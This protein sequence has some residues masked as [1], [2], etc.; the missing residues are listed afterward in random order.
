MNSSS[1]QISNTS[2]IL[3]AGLVLI[4]L[5]IGYREK[6]GIDRDMIIG[7]LRAIVQLYIVGY[8][9]KYVIKVDNIFLTV[10]LML[11]IIFNAGYNAMKRSQGIPNTLWISIGAIFISTGV[12]VGAMV[13]THALKFIPAQMIPITGMMASQSMVAIGLCYRNL[14]TN[15]HDERQ[16]VLEKLSLG[17]NIKQ[18][19]M[20]I[21]RESIK[22]GMQ[23]TVDST[24]T[25]GI[26]TLP[27]MMSGLIFAGIDPVYAIEYQIMITFM[28]LAATSLGSV[29]AVYWSY[30]GFYNREDQLVLPTSAPKKKHH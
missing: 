14:N 21:L 1:L 24:K 17:G 30:K 19:S 15:F 5:Y 4:A 2:L 13:L 6:L 28:L 3:A 11:I 10:V 27:G 7:V 29:M 20:H 25:M 16:Q 23:P 18:S 26:V 9:L 12:T 8:L 22:T